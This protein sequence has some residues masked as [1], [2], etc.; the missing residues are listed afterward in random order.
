ML[1]P[2][3]NFVEWIF[4]R[5]GRGIGYVIAFLLWP[6]LA[7][8]KWYRRRGWLI[9]GPIAL[10][11]LLIVASYVYLFM[12]TQFWRGFD[13]NYVAAYN[14]KERG[15]SAGER[16]TAVSDTSAG[17]TGTTANAET[18]APSAVVQVTQDLVDMNVNQNQWIPSTLFYKL[19]F[20]GVEWKRTPFFDNRAAFQL[21][22]NQAVRRTSAELIDRLGRVRGT[23]QLDQDLQ[24]A[25]EAMFYPENLWYLSG[26]RPVQTTPSR[27]REAIPSFY[28]FNQ[29]LASCD[30][31]FDPRADNLVQ[32]LDRVA[33]DIG[34]TSDILRERAEAYN[35]GWFDTRADDRFWFT[36]GQLYGYAG[37][38]AGARAD[39]DD[40]IKT[41][42]LTAVW[43]R[44]ELQFDQALAMQPSIISNGAEDGWIMPTHLATAGFYVLRVRSNLVELRDV[45][46]R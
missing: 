34:S 43:D 17:G 24:N 10:V 15:V 38:L 30:A 12:I 20:F 25:R 16:I 4:D 41:R 2:I 27:F 5:I 36:Y 21:G 28:K 45:L 9:K 7:F 11:L 37:V 22:V 13:Q 19:G 1:D 31:T 6:F 42:G 8:G 18:C 26:I 3:I 14:F 33:A 29:R 39:F 23:S 32:F 40:V 46:D 44:M 35:S